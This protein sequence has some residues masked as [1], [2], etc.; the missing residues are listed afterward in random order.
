VAIVQAG[1]WLSHPHFEYPQFK[2][3]WQLSI[4]TSAFVLHLSHIIDPAGNVNASPAPASPFS[5]PASAL[6]FE[7][8]AS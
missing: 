1:N 2:Q 4:N 3:V 5:A 6:F 8:A 7:P